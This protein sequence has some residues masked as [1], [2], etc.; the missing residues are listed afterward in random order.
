MLMKTHSHIRKIISCA[1]L[2]AAMLLPLLS[3]ALS[4]SSVQA[5][6]SSITYNNSIFTKKLY[7]NTEKI[8]L[9]PDGSCI[10]QDKKTV[11]KIYTLLAG[12]KLKAKT[13]D[14]GKETGAFRVVL[15][16]K[17]GKKLTC[18]FLKHELTI[19]NKAYAITKNNPLKALDAIYSSLLPDDSSAK[20]LAAASYPE[21]AQYPSMESL[22]QDDG[23]FEAWNSQRQDRQKTAEQLDGGIY[24]FY[25]AS[26][27]EFLSGAD[28]KN[29]V[30]SPVNV[31]MALSMLAEITGG[32]S[33]SQLLSLLSVKDADTLT[34]QAKNLWTANYR[35]DGATTSILANSLWLNNSV[36]VNKETIGKL[37]DDY[38]ASVYRGDPAS[39]EM[40]K[41]LQDWLNE[42]TGGLLKDS[43][44]S[45]TLTP[46]TILELCSTVYFRAKW[47]HE[48]FKE[49]NDTKTFHSPDGDRDAEFMNST[50]TG[51]TY[52]RGDGFGA[53]KLNFAEGGAMWL[54][55][56]DEGRTPE[57]LLK[58]GE[59]LDM[60]G[61]NYDWE[62]QKR[63][64]INLSVPK[65]DVSSDI[66]LDDGLKALGVTDIFDGEKSDFTP[67]AGNG[68]KNIT[69]SNA[70]HAARVVADEEGCTAA[71][72]TVIPVT[73]TGMPLEDTIDFV[74]DRPFL[75]VIQSDTDQPLFTGI[76]NQP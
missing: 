34:A 76:V 60:A 52:Y 10:V 6:G 56:P 43:V 37:A 4:K 65:F 49:H 39:A 31:Y 8:G 32:N 64:T 11:K 19:K 58:S 72:Y 61:S 15:H 68:S 35:N 44:D 73:G 24:S 62:N 75:F 9:G 3:P 14:S 20:A 46:Q 2:A 18:S 36:A 1:L 74:V 57:D 13:Q 69:V 22:E 12:M 5:Q 45:I 50:H 25:K 21:A 23:T 55:L 41:A 17:N 7:K 38:Y 67:L 66:E 26:S 33:K 28:G 63:L 71:A 47:D 27:R 54:I 53:T 42:Q 29:R 51:G 40:T 48:F 16:K 30:Y 70:K 59:Y